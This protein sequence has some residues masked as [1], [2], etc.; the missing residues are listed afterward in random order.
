MVRSG[1]SH[2]HQKTFQPNFIHH[3]Y[4]G[5]TSHAPRELL[6]YTSQELAQ[7]TNSRRV[8]VP[9]DGIPQEVPEPDRVRWLQLLITG[10]L[11]IHRMPGPQTRLQEQC[12]PK[13]SQASRSDL[14][15]RTGNKDL[16]TRG[17]WLWQKIP[18]HPPQHYLRNAAN[19]AEHIEMLKK[20]V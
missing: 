12:F 15:K 14:Y 4:S 20:K 18:N 9:I 3:Y 2:F 19:S 1:T 13:P 17:G 7:K 10:H 6:H 8:G 5:S 11:E 16:T